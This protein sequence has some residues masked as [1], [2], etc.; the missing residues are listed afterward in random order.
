[1]HSWRARNLQISTAELS[2]NCKG[3]ASIGSGFSVLQSREV[4]FRW[5]IV[6]PEFTAG[7]SSKMVRSK[8]ARPCM[9]C[10]GCFAGD[11]SYSHLTNLK[12]S[13][14]DRKVP[15]Q[16]QSWSMPYAVL[17]DRSFDSM[18]V[19]ESQHSQTGVVR[20]AK[21]QCQSVWSGRGDTT[22]IRCSAIN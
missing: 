13:D 12:R 15:D 1:M 16:G 22:V 8:P 9:I 18:P 2:E 17:V 6:I 19:G 20:V 21:T 11:I 7:K 5:G 3:N 10:K 4:S 14:P